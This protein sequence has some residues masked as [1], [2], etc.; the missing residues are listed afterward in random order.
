[1]RPLARYFGGLNVVVF[2][3]EDLALP[4]GAP[5]DRR[6]FLDRGVFNLRPDYLATAQESSRRGPTG[7]S[8]VRLQ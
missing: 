3:H 2:T 6:R 4:R 8:H 1:M 5:G 7:W